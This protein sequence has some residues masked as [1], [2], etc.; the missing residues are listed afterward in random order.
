[1]TKATVRWFDGLAGEGMVRLEDGK[2]VYVHFTAIEGISKNNHHYP[3]ASDV[4]SL[5]AL[6]GKECMVEIFEDSHYRQISKLVL[7]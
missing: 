2:C 6:D 7:K 5:K 3:L 4:P 1:M